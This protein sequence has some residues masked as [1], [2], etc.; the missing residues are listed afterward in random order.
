[1]LFSFSFE[2][3]IYSKDKQSPTF[4]FMCADGCVWY[5]NHIPHRSVLGLKRCVVSA[6]LQQT[7]AQSSFCS[8]KVKRSGN[9]EGNT[10]LSFT[11]VTLGLRDELR[12]NNMNVI[13]VM[14]SSRRTE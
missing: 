7:D 6:F 5:Q 13:R 14:C 12:D 2:H 3:I 4:A 8:V 1:M 10:F 9:N 11:N